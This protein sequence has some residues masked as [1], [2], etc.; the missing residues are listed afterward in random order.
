MRGEF[1]DTPLHDASQSGHLE[2]VKYIVEEVK[3]NPEVMDNYGETPLDDASWGGHLEIVK[4]LVEEVKVNPET[5]D[6]NGDTPLHRASRYGRLEIVKYFIRH[7]VDTSMK[8]NKDETFLDLLG[9]EQKEEI[10]KMIEDLQWRKS[11]VKSGRF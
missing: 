10:E 11:N 4:Y 5:L 2:I 8:N 7:D 3:V 1:G 9:V 6:N